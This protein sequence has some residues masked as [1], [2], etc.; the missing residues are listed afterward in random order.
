MYMYVCLH[1]QTYTNKHTHTHTHTH[2]IYI[3]APGAGVQGAR[4]SAAQERVEW[5]P[6]DKCAPYDKKTMH[7]KMPVKVAKDKMS[8][9]VASISGPII[10]VYFH[11]SGIQNVFSIEC[12]LY[13]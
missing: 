12:V 2:I 6:Y 10:D 13:M 7:H 8:E 5:A 9:N 3:V 11:A 4:R 1:T